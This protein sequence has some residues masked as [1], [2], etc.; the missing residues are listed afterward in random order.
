M[1]LTVSLKG[2]CSSA[3]WATTERRRNDYAGAMVKFR[4]TYRRTAQGEP[5]GEPQR[6]D[7]WVEADR[8][9]DPD[10]WFDFVSDDGEGGV[11]SVLRIRK[12]SVDR[13][14]RIEPT[15]DYE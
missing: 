7:D 8:Y 1:G 13:I 12:N 3:E 2:M 14:E 9:L 4:V 10:D 6:V 15:E 11:V 5:P